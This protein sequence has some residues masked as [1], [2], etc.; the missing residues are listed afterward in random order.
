MK[1]TSKLLSLITI[2]LL[3]ILSL[4]L[5]SYAKV[6]TGEQGN[7]TWT[8]DLNRSSMVISGTGDME[9]YINYENTPYSRFLPVIKTLT[10]NEGITSVGNCAFMYALNLESINLPSS[11]EYIGSTA[12]SSC[13]K[14]DGVALP[15]NLTHL[16]E[17]AF[18]ECGKLKNI[19]CRFSESEWVEPEVGA[20][21]T[22][23]ES[24]NIS[25]DN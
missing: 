21:N 16:G 4:S 11:V 10:V 17:Y 19:F 3:I 9:N 22:P 5:F 12:F 20:E 1:K 8:V 13:R 2:S 25:F 24:V 23:Y 15:S 18:S 7:I 14:L 6:Y